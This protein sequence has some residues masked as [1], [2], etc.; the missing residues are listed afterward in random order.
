MGR[1]QVLDPALSPP[2]PHTPTLPDSL[3]EERRTVQNSSSV[4]LFQ[5][6]GPNKHIRNHGSLTYSYITN[7]HNLRLTRLVA[8]LPEGKNFVLPSYI[9]QH[10]G[11]GCFPVL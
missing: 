8:T 9:N 6:L 2:L 7:V 1:N 10:G 4:G 3:A 5:S 11:L